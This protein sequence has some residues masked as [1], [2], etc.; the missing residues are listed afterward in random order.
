MKK[1]THVDIYYPSED[2]EVIHIDRIVVQSLHVCNYI[3]PSTHHT[4]LTQFLQCC[5]HNFHKNHQTFPAHRRNLCHIDYNAIQHILLCNSMRL[6]YLSR[7]IRE[8]NSYSFL[9]M[10]MMYM[11]F[12]D[13]HKNLQHTHHN[14]VHLYYSHSPNLSRIKIMKYYGKHKLRKLTIHSPVSLLQISL[15][16]LHSHGKTVPMRSSSRLVSVV[17]FFHRK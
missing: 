3:D 7:N 2:V 8:R 17:T 11:K 10:D 9:D 15:L 16:P 5:N 14:D 13:D 4:H 12:L 6:H 1:I